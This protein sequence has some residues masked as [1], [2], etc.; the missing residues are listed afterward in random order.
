[1]RKDI[2]DLRK[3]MSAQDW[4]EKSK[5]IYENLIRMPVYQEAE[6]VLA[7]ISISNEPDTDEIIRHAME[8]GKT[9]AVPKCEGRDLGFYRIDS[10]DDVSP[11]RFS[12]PE[13]VNTDD[14]HRVVMTEKSLIILPGL[15]FD[16]N[17]FRLG[18]G[19]GFYDRYLKDDSYRNKLMIAFSFQEVG[20]VPNHSGDVPVDWI[21]TEKEIIEVYYKVYGT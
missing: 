20:H 18:Y 2:S 1:M 15:A 6:A 21:V 16:K 12:V 9:V 10:P 5:S 3:R 13:P 4:E 17:G 7:F 14:L 8:A 11:G 19:A